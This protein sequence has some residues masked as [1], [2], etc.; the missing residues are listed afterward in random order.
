MRTMGI[1][2]GGLLMAFQPRPATGQESDAQKQA[3]Q[4]FWVDHSDAIMRYI[5]SIQAVTP[6]SFIA[7]RKTVNGLELF[8]SRL[9]LPDL[10]PAA[11][12]NH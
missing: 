12:C 1:L 10:P 2:I 3:V 4:K 7:A 5:H 8:E 6:G 11:P 9:P